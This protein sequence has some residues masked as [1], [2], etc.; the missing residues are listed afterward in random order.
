M[1]SELFRTLVLER[2]R[3]PL[4]VTNETCSC[5]AALDTMG[6]HRVCPRS[7][8]LKTKAQGPERSLVRICREAGAFVRFNAKLRDLNLAV[9]VND[10][11]VIEVLASGLPSTMARNW[12][13]TSLRHHFHGAP[14]HER[15]THQRGSV[16][17][18]EACQGT[19]VQR[20]VATGAV[21]S[22]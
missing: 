13:S 16:D 20:V 12:P 11:R 3:L 10:V 18:F 5:G 19:E 22:S 4:N 15:R 21:C 9:S 14:C 1:Q 8:L 6:R 2:L 7:G 17:G